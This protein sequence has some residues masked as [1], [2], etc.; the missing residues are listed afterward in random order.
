MKKDQSTDE[1]AQASGAKIVV[2][3]GGTGSFV[4][5]SGLKHYA[6]SITA[7]VSMADDGGSTGKL[8]DEY[9][10][11]PAGDVRQCLVALSKSPKVRDLFNYRFDGGGLEG[12]NFGNIF[13]TALEKMTGSFSEG[14][15]LASEILQ[16][17]GKVEPITLD[18]VTL[19]IK[20]GKKTIRHEHTID[21]LVFSEQRP[22]IW[23]E[24]E[25]KINPAATKA[26]ET[27]D[28]IIIAPGSLYT[29]LGA[30]LSVPKVGKALKK[31]KAKKIYVCNLVNKPGQTD[32]F[33]VSDYADEIERM[34]GEKF[35]DYV[36]YN[37]HQPGKKLLEKYAAEGELPVVIES[38]V[39]KKAHY[40]ARGAELLASEV[41]QNPNAKDPLAGQR[42]LIRHDPD[43]T[44]RAIMKIYFS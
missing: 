15:E 35:L 14:V 38:S 36:I 10:A 19:V 30:A 12:H 41:W 5:L 23:L 20:D 17:N 18:P 8:R 27:A 21:D 39:L 42:T 3:G 29:S 25:P 22:E 7:L 4:L 40:K 26:I 2:I 24:P 43:T 34:A 37:V 28:L 13:L 31:S 1:K 6:H 44:A 9:G 33:S 32:D 16:V 11:L